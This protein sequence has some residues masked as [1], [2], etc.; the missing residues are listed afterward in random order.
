MPW[1]PSPGDDSL[2]NMMPSL[3]LPAADREVEI[4]SPEVRDKEYMPRR[5]R[6]REQDFE[7]FGRTAGCKGYLANMRGAAYAIHS[8]A[9]RARMQTGMQA[10]DEGR[11]RTRERIYVHNRGHP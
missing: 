1:Q 5:I 10:T 9:C 6:L 7:E 11:R 4:R 2:E 8:D 3:D